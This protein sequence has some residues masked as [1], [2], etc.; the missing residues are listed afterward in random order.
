MKEREKSKYLPGDVCKKMKENGYP[1]FNS[2]QHTILWKEMDAKN[3]KKG[4]GT[5]VAKT[6]YWYDNWI[7]IVKTHCSE[8]GDKYK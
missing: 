3:P 6:W 5:Q 2:Y 4:F 8:S 1:K 7:Q